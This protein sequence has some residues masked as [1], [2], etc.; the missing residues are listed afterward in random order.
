[1]VEVDIVVVGDRRLDYL[2]VTLDPDVEVVAPPE[3]QTRRR[4]HA[5]TLL[6]AYS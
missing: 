1:L 6:A 4:E 3:A 2:L 5:A